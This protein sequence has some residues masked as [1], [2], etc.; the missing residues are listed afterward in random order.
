MNSKHRA[1]ALEEESKKASQAQR[2]AEAERR[3]AEKERQERASECLVW[4]EKHRE[5]A[6]EFRAQDDLKALRQSKSVR[7]HPRH[8]ALL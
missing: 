1:M 3:L 5:L 6:A 4:R 2:E 7:K 8:L